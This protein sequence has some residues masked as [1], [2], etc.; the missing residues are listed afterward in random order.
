MTLII[1]DVFLNY[2]FLV[3]CKKKRKKMFGILF[4]TIYFIMLFRHKEHDVKP[5]T[6]LLMWIDKKICFGY[7]PNELLQ[8]IKNPLFDVTLC[9]FYLF[10][11]IIPITYTCYFY[12][13]NQ[14]Q[15]FLLLWGMTN[16]Q[17]Y[18]IQKIIP[19]SPPWYNNNDLNHKEGDLKRI[20]ELIGQPLFYSIY[21]D[22]NLT[23]GALP[24]LHVAWVMCFVLLNGFNV[25]STAHLFCISL[26][27][28]YFQHHYLIDVLLGILIPY[29]S[30]EIIKI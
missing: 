5:N 16:L 13:Q 14:L 24:S 8:K 21:K 1:C 6:T 11:F 15:L 18:C 22:N 23:Y 25:W 7:L 17:A 28:I 30:Y 4:N 3:L 10:H 26:A 2:D 12:C 29:L 19:T 27:A 20:D 9:F